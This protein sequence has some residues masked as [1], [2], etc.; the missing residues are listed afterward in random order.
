LADMLN[1]L[2]LDCRPECVSRRRLDIRCFHNGLI[3]GI[4]AS[5]ENNTGVDV[6]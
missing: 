4:E 2:G 3:I 6:L 1:K 5:L